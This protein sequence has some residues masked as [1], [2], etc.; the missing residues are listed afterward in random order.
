MS[1]DTSITVFT[2]IDYCVQDL[3]RHS[4]A[5]SSVSILYEVSPYEAMLYEAISKHLG[6]TPHGFIWNRRGKE[7]GVRERYSSIVV[8]NR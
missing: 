6:P 7:N 5:R 3:D 2:I 4:G 1:R 8:G